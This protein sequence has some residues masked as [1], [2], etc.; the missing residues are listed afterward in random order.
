MLGQK[1]QRFRARIGLQ[2]SV[3]RLLQ[4]LGQH[5]ADGKVVVNDG[6]GF[7]EVAPLHGDMDLA[8]QR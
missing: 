3:T 4:K 7:H 6:N 8:Y 5:I 1:I 2:N